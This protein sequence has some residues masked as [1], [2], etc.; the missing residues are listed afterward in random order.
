MNHL[1]APKAALPENIHEFGKYLKPNEKTKTNPQS[2]MHLKM[3][4]LSFLGLD[5][6]G[7]FDDISKSSEKKVPLSS[8]PSLFRIPT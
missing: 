3:N 6:P 1:F 8:S 2:L 4:H 7:D 5:S